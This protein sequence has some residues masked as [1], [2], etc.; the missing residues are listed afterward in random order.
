M[1]DYYGSITMDN[2]SIKNEFYKKYGDYSKTY[3]DDKLKQIGTFPA[4]E[5]YSVSG[6]RVFYA[7][8]QHKLFQESVKKDL[9]IA[10]KKVAF[11][12]AI[13]SDFLIPDI[14]ESVSKQIK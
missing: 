14:I 3:I 6:W 12:K 5:S 7:P 8:T 1:L 4:G 9:E 2:Q 10:Q 13:Y 11:M